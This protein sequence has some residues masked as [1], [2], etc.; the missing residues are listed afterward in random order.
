MTS[1]GFFGLVVIPEALALEQQL[2]AGDLKKQFS[3][4]SSR[5]V[6]TFPVI[7]NVLRLVTI[8]ISHLEPPHEDAEWSSCASFPRATVDARFATPHGIEFSP[9]P[10]APEHPI[11]ASAIDPKT[12]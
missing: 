1:P 10:T 4:V 7:V 8:V 3:A 9:F 12:R 2:C 11:L 6:F 5:I